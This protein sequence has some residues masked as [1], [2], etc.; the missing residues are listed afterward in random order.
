MP[1]SL[2][3][4]QKP[5]QKLLY[6]QVHNYVFRHG[7]HDSASCDYCS[8][9]NVCGDGL[10]AVITV[11]HVTVRDI[12]QPLRKLFFKL[13]KERLCFS[14]DNRCASL[15]DNFPNTAETW[16]SHLMFSDLCALFFYVQTLAEKLS[17]WNW[18]V[19]SEERVLLPPWAAESK[20]L[21]N[22]YCKRKN[23]F[24]QSK[25]FK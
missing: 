19:A 5:K 10:M 3:I 22:E 21:Q 18:G 9:I 11:A 25:T 7:E 23:Y 6:R 15:V 1:A 20:M 12:A 2:D 8:R 4:F 17:V 16:S 14:H 13:P 24:L